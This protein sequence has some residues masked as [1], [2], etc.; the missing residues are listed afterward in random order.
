[1]RLVVAPRHL[2]RVGEA[3]SAFDEPVL[4]R[5]ETAQGRRRGGEKVIV[6]DTVGELAAFYALAT[7][8]VIG[9]SFYPG[10]N[11]HNPIESAALGVSTVFGPYMRNFVDPARELL[12][13]GGAVQVE[14]PEGLLPVLMRLLG[15]PQERARI[16]A[17]GREA[18]LA[19]QGATERNLDLIARVSGLG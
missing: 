13:R 16:G 2:E 5:S 4:R 18:V 1:L 12:A 11:G 6:L 17:R 10:V 15:D 7:L 9:G 14:R 3:V 19:N 8:V